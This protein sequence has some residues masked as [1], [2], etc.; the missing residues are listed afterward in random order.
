MYFWF[1]IFL[2]FLIYVFFIFTDSS[3]FAEAFATGYL[4]GEVL[5]KHQLQDDFESFSQSR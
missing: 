1:M 5:K 3:N 2:K 4:I